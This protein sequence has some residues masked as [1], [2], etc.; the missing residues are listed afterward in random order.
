MMRSSQPALAALRSRLPRTRTIAAAEVSCQATLAGRCRSAPSRPG[1]G[2]LLSG[3]M[4][5]RRAPGS[6]I[7]GSLGNGVSSMSIEPPRKP[8]NRPRA[9]AA[10]VAADLE[11]LAAQQQA[12][13]RALPPPGRRRGRGDRGRRLRQ[14]GP[15]AAGRCRCKRSRRR[16]RQAGARPLRLPEGGFAV[17]AVD[18]RCR[19][20]AWPAGSKVRGHGAR[21]RST[22]SAASAASSSAATW[23]SSSPTSP[24]SARRCWAPPPT[25]RC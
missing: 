3:H 23:W 22:P 6:C 19:T 15:G 2:S 24:S 12:E 5:R 20:W 10:P 14:P 16:A 7:G 18:R 11:A 8:P 9:P 4:P 17:A 21:R 13:R 25:P 1:G